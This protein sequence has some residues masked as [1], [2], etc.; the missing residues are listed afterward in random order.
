[1]SKKAKS[2]VSVTT[3]DK[4]PY[5]MYTADQ[6]GGLR[7][8]LDPNLS[9]RQRQELPPVYVLNGAVYAIYTD[10]LLNTREF[11]PEGTLP[12]LMSKEHSVDVDYQQDLDFV[13]FLLWKN[14]SAHRENPEVS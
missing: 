4:S 6:R 5:W 2:C 14:H 12:Y 3:P 13:E 7:P 9:G 8:L 11:V 1:M 10:L